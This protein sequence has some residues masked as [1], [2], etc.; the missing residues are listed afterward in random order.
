MHK[1]LSAVLVMMLSASATVASAAPLYNNVY[2]LRRINLLNKGASMTLVN[3]QE[4]L[5]LPSGETSNYGINKE[6]WVVIDDGNPSR[7]TCWMEA[8][9]KK[10][11]IMKDLSRF[12]SLD[13]ENVPDNL[14]TLLNWSGHFVGYAYANPVTSYRELH[15]MPIGNS[16]PT[17]SFTYTITGAP[18][19]V[20]IN[21]NQVLSVP[22]FRCYDDKA[23]IYNGTSSARVDFGLEIKEDNVSY[24]SGTAIENVQFLNPLTNKMEAISSTADATTT[25]FPGAFVYRN[26]KANWTPPT[27]TS[28]NR[29][30]FTR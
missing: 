12:V 26:A 11:L 19:Q 14:G 1:T 15:A 21:G 24:R 28:K 25:P 3:G 30:T 22:A 27:A 4:D 8:G 29:I 2:I 13:T 6:M 18:W 5:F 17:G 20:S 10:G 9:Q 7:T 23:G 16:N